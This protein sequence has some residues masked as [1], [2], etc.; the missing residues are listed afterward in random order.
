MTYDDLTPS[1]KLLHDRLGSP[2]QKVIFLQRQK[3]YG[4]FDQCHAN[5][6]MAWTALIQNHYH[7]QLDKPIPAF[8]AALMLSAMKHVRATN[9]FHQDNYDDML[10]YDQFANALQEADHGAA[11]QV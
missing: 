9:A 6:G 2:E 11:K 3:T 1:Q 7:I 5:L 8:L 10:N 4:P